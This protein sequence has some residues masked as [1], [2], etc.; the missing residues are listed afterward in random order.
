[1]KTSIKTILMLSAFVLSSYGQDRDAMDQFFKSYISDSS[2]APMTA[3][4]IYLENNEKG[5]SYQKG[6]GTMS[7]QDYTEVSKNSPFKTAS[8]TKM[9]T[10]T[11]VLQLVEQGKL[12]LSDKISHLLKHKDYINFQDLHQ[13]NGASYGKDITIE[14]LLNHTSGLAD[15]FTDTE[16]KFIQLFMS[17]PTRQWNPEIL[18]KTYYDFNLNA[19]AH[20]VPGTDFYYSD[21]NYFLL[22]LLIEEI[23]KD[24]LAK[25][26]RKGI[27]EPAKMYDT[28]FEY[29]EVAT[30][31][32]DMPSTYLQ[33]TELNADIN[34]SFDWAGGGLVSTTQDLALF[35]HALFDNT[36]IKNQE[37]LDKMIFDNGNGY[38]Y[39]IFIY[40]FE[41]DTYYGHSGYWGSMVCHNPN[42][43]KTLALSINQSDPDFS[44]S[45]LIK[46]SLKFMD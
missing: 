32:M 45:E 39:G 14:Q 26:Y 38:G 22:G 24:P 12:K 33:N 34:T 28:Y 41:N 20:F 4:V 31:E 23:T 2:E 21:T 8:I 40:Q 3:L 6:F 9:F 7:T 30:Q 43:D 19:Q 11:L 18:F 42:K 37:L 36:L 27:L 5:F 15:I 16:D 25:A 1:M 46:K 17:D 44:F 13:F 10:A 29:H 35:M